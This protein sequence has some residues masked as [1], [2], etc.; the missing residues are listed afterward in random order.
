MTQYRQE[1]LYKP[2][3]RIAVI[4]TG[5]SGLGAAWALARRH[6]VCLYEQAARPG[7][8]VNTVEVEEAGRRIPV[9]TGFIVY[10]ERN[11]PRLTALLARLGVASQPSD[12]SFGVSIG[13]GA[14]EYAGDNLRS[15]FAQPANLFSPAHWGMLRDILRFNREAKRFLRAP[16]PD[17]SLGGFLARGGYGRRLRE[18]YLLPMGA[19]I[20]SC[21]PRRMLDFPAASLLRFFA[22]HG[23]LDLSGRP[24]WR[25]LR[26]GAREYVARLLADFPGECR[27]ATPV[28]RVRH[29]PGGPEVR[30]AHGHAE[31]FDAVVLAVHAD[32]ALA[33]LADPAPGHRRLLGAFR[34]QNN[35]ALLHSDPA[36]MPRRRRIWSSW[37]YLADAGAD[38]TAAVS[39]SYWMN[40][41][42]SLPARRDYFVSL[43]P[44]REPDPARV[45]YATEYRHPVFSRAA[46]AAQAGLDAL[47]GR[48]G[49]WFC[50]AWCGYGFHEDGLR[51]GLAVA[52]R[53]GAPAPWEAAPAHGPAP[54]P[55]AG[56]AA[57]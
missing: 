4:G 11:Y 26:G 2:V 39:V 18:A 20:W 30:D 3:Q 57:A 28:S 14:L 9:D 13:A 31:R 50:G 35:R 34:Y 56:E 36:L 41:L 44:L 17:L 40:R 23:L 47:Q 8:H 38:G 5:V 21:P 45:H 42:Q 22:N 1:H 27:F 6:D 29:G 54:C 49:L 48:R 43:N 7:G 55:A 32:Q 19:A 33:L 25:T 10:N 16:D 52:A 46:V 15:L 24:Q 51:A 37:N 53:L 12:M